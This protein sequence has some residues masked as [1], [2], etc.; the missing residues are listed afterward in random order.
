MAKTRTA[1]VQQGIED[2]LWAIEQGAREDF[3]SSS[4]GDFMEKKH[5]EFK[6]YLFLWND[7]YKKAK[8][9]KDLMF[10][11][12]Q[13]M[14]ANACGLG[15]RHPLLRKYMPFPEPLKEYKDSKKAP[16][17]PLCMNCRYAPAK[18]LP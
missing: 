1:F 18:H 8:K 11:I 14:S 7:E 2:M 9:L 13:R 15:V 17:D 6:E 16:A 3:Y 5:N 4:K 10:L 12:R